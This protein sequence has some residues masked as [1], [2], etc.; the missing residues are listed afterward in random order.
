MYHTNLVGIVSRISIKL[1]TSSLKS[2]NTVTVTTV[3]HCVEN[4]AIVLTLISKFSRFL[5][6]YF[7]TCPLIIELCPPHSLF[8]KIGC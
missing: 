7:L 4:Y 2:D 5:H 8:L 1:P 6:F 3:S